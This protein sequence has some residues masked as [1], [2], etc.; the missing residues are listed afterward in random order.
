MT[1]LIDLRLEKNA[2][3]STLPASWSSFTSLL[4]VELD[5]NALTGTLPSEWSAWSSIEK[6]YLDQNALTGTLPSS[7]SAWTTVEKIYLDTNALTGTLPASWS[8]LDSLTHLTLDANQ[9]TSTIPTSW[10]ALSDTGH[11]I[12]LSDNTGLYGDL[13]PTWDSH[14]CKHTG[15][16]I[17]IIPP[18]PETAA[19]A[20]APVEPAPIPVPVTYEEP[21]AITPTQVPLATE[22]V[23]V[24]STYEEP[25]TIAPTQAP[26]VVEP[27]VVPTSYDKSPAIAPSKEPLAAEPIVVPA[28]YEEPPAI[29]PTQTPLEAEP[30]VTPAEYRESPFV[31]P[32]Q[33]P[34]EAEPTSVPVTVEDSPSITPLQTPLE[35]EPVVVPMSSEDA[36]L[37]TPSELTLEPAPIATPIS[38]EE[39]PSVTP[40]QA[41]VETEPI[42]VPAMY[43]ESPSITPSK[44]PLEAEPVTVPLSYEDTPSIAPLQVPLEAEPV[45]MPMSYEDSPVIEPSPVNLEPEYIDMPSPDVIQLE[46]AFEPISI[47]DDYSKFK[48]MIFTFSILSAV[49]LPDVQPSEWPTET[50]E[51]AITPWI[52][53]EPNEMEG[54][55]VSEW[56]QA[57]PTGEEELT[58]SSTILTEPPIGEEEEILS[59]TIQM[60]PLEEDASM[61]IPWIADEPIEDD[62]STIRSWIQT[63]PVEEQEPMLTP[64]IRTEPTS[65]E[66]DDDELLM[67]PWI[68]IELSEYEGSSVAPI[69]EDLD[70]ELMIRCSSVAIMCDVIGNTVYEEVIVG[71]TF[72]G[73]DS[74]PGSPGFGIKLV[75]TSRPTKPGEPYEIIYKYQLSPCGPVMESVRLVSVLCSED[76]YYCD[77]AGT[78]F[79]SST[80]LCVDGESV[81]ESLDNEEILKEKFAPPNIELIGSGDIEISVGESYSPCNA[82]IDAIMEGSPSFHCDSIVEATDLVEGSLTERVEACSSNSSTN[83]LSEVGLAGCNITTDVPGIHNINFTVR[84]SLGVETSISRQIF[85]VPICPEG[86]VVCREAL[87]CSSDGSCFV[88]TRNTSALDDTDLD[89]FETQELTNKNNT[90]EL[91]LTASLGERVYLTIGETYEKCETGIQPT[92]NVKCEPGAKV[93]ISPSQPSEYEIYVCPS[94]TCRHGGVELCEAHLFRTK[95]LESCNI[96]TNAPAGTQY[97]LTFM[98]VP[99]NSTLSPLF[100]SRYLVLMTPCGDKQYPCEGSCSPLPCDQL[101]SLIDDDPPVLTLHYP[102]GL[103]LAY[104]VE[105]GYSIIPCQ[106]IRSEFCGASA[107]DEEDGDL[108]STIKIVEITPCESSTC[109]YCNPLYFSSGG[110]LPGYY[111]YIYSVV[112]SAGNKISSQTM[113]VNIVELADI[114]LHVENSTVGGSLGSNYIMEEMEA[115]E[116]LKST[117]IQT[118]ENG[119]SLTG[120]QTSLSEEDINL[121]LI[122]GVL[123]LQI[124]VIILGN[125]VGTINAATAMDISLEK[126][127]TAVSA[128]FHSSDVFSVH[129]TRRLLQDVVSEEE[130]SNSTVEEIVELSLSVLRAT[131]LTE[132]NLT[133]NGTRSTVVTEAINNAQG[134][135]LSVLG[136]LDTLYQASVSKI[137]ELVE[138]VRLSVPDTSKTEKEWMIKIDTLFADQRA[139]L[140]YIQNTLK[141]S[142]DQDLLLDSVQDLVNATKSATSEMMA[143]IHEQF[144]DLNHMRDYQGFLNK[145]NGLSSMDRCIDDLVERKHSFTVLRL[146]N[147][148]TILS[149][150]SESQ[151]STSI[152]TSVT[153]EDTTN[154]VWGS[155]VLTNPMIYDFGPQATSMNTT[156]MLRGATNHK[157][158]IVGGTVIQT[159]RRNKEHIC[160]GRFAPLDNYCYAIPVHKKDMS[161]I[162]YGRDPVFLVDSSLYDEKS[163]V[164]GGIYYDMESQDIS[165]TGIPYG[166]FNSEV[167]DKLETHF[168]YLDIQFGRTTAVKMLQYLQ[169]G[170][171]M[172]SITNT[173]A[174]RFITYNPQFPLTILGVN[175]I[176]CHWETDIRCEHK[177]DA[178]PDV[179]WNGKSPAAKQTVG[180][181]CGSIVLTAMYWIFLVRNITK[182]VYLNKGTILVRALAFK[183]SADI[184]VALALVVSTIMTAILISYE[185]ADLGERLRFDIYDSNHFTGAHWLL[186][187]QSSI[188]SSDRWSMPVDVTDII[189]LSGF[190]ERMD[191]YRHLASLNSVF[192]TIAL[193]GMI[194]R[195]LS[196][197][198]VML[199]VSTITSTLASCVEP[200]LYFMIPF[201]LLLVS[202]AVVGSTCFGYRVESLSSFTKA[203]TSS[204]EFVFFGE[205]MMELT[206]EGT[207]LHPVERVTAV[208]YKAS[209]TCF[210]MFVFLHF[211]LGILTERFLHEKYQNKRKST[212][213]IRD[214]IPSKTDRLSRLMTLLEQSLHE[215]RIQLK[216]IIPCCTGASAKPL[217]DSQIDEESETFSVPKELLQV[218]PM[219]LQSVRWNALY[220]DQFSDAS[221]VGMN[222]ED[223][224]SVPLKI[225]AAVAPAPNRSPQDLLRAMRSLQV[226]MVSLLRVYRQ[227]REWAEQA[228]DELEACV[229]IY[230]A[231]KEVPIQSMHSE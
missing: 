220:Q 211:I 200:L 103:T 144:R 221:E 21:P 46:P 52:Q 88:H 148:S 181:I 20:P 18:P 160:Y 165:P 112:D 188:G 39:S 42:D 182:T 81:D 104:G 204:M 24:P 172:D 163:A 185:V 219:E 149:S 63:E 37:I 115:V 83:Y 134:T 142:L 43:E 150:G 108:S 196:M 79:C 230:K 146:G 164:R 131:D 206:P 8:N 10:S 124:P 225:L 173:V 207:L 25:P 60:E 222:L 118:L 191:T 157:N 4:L 187:K 70:T 27:A 155:Y 105:V 34:L 203:V 95:G 117:L 7:W 168:V 210:S 153:D 205:L 64:W 218:E 82:C 136:E 119:L 137:A 170:R 72:S 107:Q 132:L 75:D 161:K 85:V 44:A 102:S 217:E 176:K 33:T 109:R 159:D 186:H 65:E 116:E 145:I 110:C 229:Q 2:L 32:S 194:I 16:S 101:L 26:L 189:Q 12:D 92:D 55:L 151:K 74:N 193:M 166:F 158:Y 174:V 36:P 138:S 202:F 135:I 226:A 68:Q 127:T 96:D 22:P 154:N 19:A 13:P 216:Q 84:D 51:L 67:T 45:L 100:V 177:I 141:D 29:T 122:D 61:L 11:D 40:Y 169:E 69:S 126:S 152:E 197:G 162:P 89:S 62:E 215:K 86:E 224:S 41:P 199:K 53:I 77:T 192:Q 125:I 214:L 94:V 93:M 227:T 212:L 139:Y 1:G 15:T 228:T 78:P 120:K 30:V 66:E 3:T 147:E 5:E 59:S 97:E 190:L 47:H 49:D 140:S 58:S 133:L 213:T 38:S 128:L 54:P 35:S 231:K 179:N 201:L 156:T 171:F 223:P 195:L 73:P 17:G 98:A 57:E 198:S 50:P 123:R 113:E 106:R 14:L 71:S 208:I 31:A 183:H 167:P 114:E 56:L 80:E 178:L 87:A 129:S 209:L 121:V 175:K 6:L 91:I 9:L 99:S 143:M 130:S 90:L 111:T 28:I 23:V 184:L 48:P 76:K 180:L